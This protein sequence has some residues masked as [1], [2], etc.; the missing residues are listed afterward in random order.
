MD[1]VRKQTDMPR[2]VTIFKF[3]RAPRKPGFAQR[4]A[5]VPPAPRGGARRRPVILR[6]LALARS[7]GRRDACPTLALLLAWSLWS[8]I[9]SAQ[10][11]PGASAG[12]PPDRFKSGAET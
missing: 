2:A 7:L 5:G 3:L 6:V 12:L 1:S 11:S 10:N 9:V 8:Q 4:R